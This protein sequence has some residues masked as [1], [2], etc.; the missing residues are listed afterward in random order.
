MIP[1]V[2]GKMPAFSCTAKLPVLRCDAQSG[3]DRIVLDIPEDPVKMVRVADVSIKRL[4]HPE[5]AFASE[6]LITLRRRVRLERVHYLYKFIA[7]LW[8]EQYVNVIWHHDP[9]NQP[10]SRRHT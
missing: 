3:L 2:A 10:V 5:C 7:W 4:A 9:G 6:N 8:S 1:G